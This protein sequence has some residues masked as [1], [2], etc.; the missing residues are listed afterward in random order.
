MQ[1]DVRL[2]K[3]ARAVSKYHYNYHIVDT[4]AHKT[5]ITKL[6]SNQIRI[7]RYYRNGKY[8]TTGCY[9]EMPMELRDESYG[10]ERVMEY[11]TQVGT[12]F[13]LH[14]WYHKNGHIFKCINY[15]DGV[16]PVTGEYR[17]GIE[18]MNDVEIYH[19]NGKVMETGDIV[20]G[21]RKGKWTYYTKRGKIAFYEYY[22]E[23]GSTIEV[24]E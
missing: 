9:Y 8:K 5:V 14:T 16:D 4:K 2:S 11:S 18:N 3:A 17:H 21:R 10:T 7:V 20:M 23:N 24:P 13:G 1:E 6:K 12:K 19:D 22:T 15:S